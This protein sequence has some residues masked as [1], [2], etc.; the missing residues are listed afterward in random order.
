MKDYKVVI[1]HALSGDTVIG[2]IVPEGLGREGVRRRP[3]AD[4]RP[5]QLGRA[6]QVHRQVRVAKA[7]QAGPDPVDIPAGL[8]GTVMAFKGADAPPH[9]IVRG[10][11][12]QVFDTGT[13][14]APAEA[15]GLRRA[16]ERRARHHRDRHREAGRRPLDGRDRGGL[17]AAG[18]GHPGRRHAPGHRDR[19]G[20]GLRATTARST[21]PSRTSRPVAASSS[22]RPATAAAG[23]SAPCKADGRGT[24]KFNPAVG[25]PGKRKLQAVVY[26][27]DGFLAAR[28]ELGTYTAPAPERPAKA[29]KLTRQALR[30]ATRAALEVARRTRQ[31]VDIR[32]AAGL[33]MTRTVKRST[34]SI[35]LP[36]KGTKLTVTITGSTKSGLAGPAARFTDQGASEEVMSG[37]DRKIPPAP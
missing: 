19:Q 10:P 23:G 22:S 1:K 2:D 8:P 3:H 20:H 4:G 30:Q 33:N 7:A 32:S 28:L 16:Q 18:P 35:E 25:A 9:V 17:L 37:R 31:Q 6:R 24:L 11:S 29:K 14:N 15:A 36:A 13:G 26:A 12:G 34:T 27:A 5:R 21:T